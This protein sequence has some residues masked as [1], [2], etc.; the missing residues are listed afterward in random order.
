MN[1]CPIAPEFPNEMKDLAAKLG[2]IWAEHPTRPQPKLDVLQHWGTLVSEWADDDSLP[3]YVRK[4]SC[5][6]GRE[7]RHVSGR[8][9][10]VPTNNSPAQWAFVQSYRGCKPSLKDIAAEIRDD[11]VP[12]A[13]VLK[14]QEKEKATYT[15]LL[16]GKETINSAGWYLAHV[17]PIGLKARLDPTEL[18]ELDISKLKNHFRNLMNPSNMFVLQEEYGGL[19]ELPEFRD[20]MKRRVSR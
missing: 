18:A 20:Q 5:G 12:I 4:Q 6:C 19:V 15:C 8:R 17:E 7:L 11:R 16:N 3:L 9:S 1:D 10:I 14:T 2:K 13:M